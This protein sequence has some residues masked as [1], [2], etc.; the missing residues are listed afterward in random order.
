MGVVFRF[1]REWAV[2][3]EGPKL[4]V[5]IS[6]YVRYD[7][8]SVYVFI[9]NFHNPERKIML[10]VKIIFV[11]IHGFLDENIFRKSDRMW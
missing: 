10:N 6:L 11:I 3:L 4:Y 8:H 5:T 1:G 2:K 7:V 9:R